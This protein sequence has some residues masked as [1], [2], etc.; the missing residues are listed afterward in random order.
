MVNT[1][2][3]DLKNAF[4]VYFPNAKGP[5]RYVMIFS[6]SIDPL[7]FLATVRWKF[8]SFHQ[9]DDIAHFRSFQ[10]FTRINYASRGNDFLPF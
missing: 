7:K 4:L 9:N 3:P 8:I 1:A 6:T 10:S 2:N 5:L